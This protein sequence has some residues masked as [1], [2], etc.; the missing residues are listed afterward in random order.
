MN[1]NTSKKL[2]PHGEKTFV[3]ITPNGRRDVR[4]PSAQVVA[5]AVCGKVIGYINKRGGV[6]TIEEVHPA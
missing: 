6:T 4:G 1:E 2:E 5:N 3:V